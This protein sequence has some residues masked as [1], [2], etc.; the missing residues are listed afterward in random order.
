MNEILQWLGLCGCMQTE[1]QGQEKKCWEVK[2]E[3]NVK[4]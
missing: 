3:R 2:V 4:E 1:I